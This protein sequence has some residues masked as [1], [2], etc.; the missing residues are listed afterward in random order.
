VASG[1][2][3]SPDPLLLSVKPRRSVEYTPQMNR[4]PSFTALN[5]GGAV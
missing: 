1:E 4:S 2:G 3:K 5:M